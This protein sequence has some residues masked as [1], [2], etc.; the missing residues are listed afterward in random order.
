[1]KHVIYVG[2]LNVWKIDHRNVDLNGLICLGFKI[3]MTLPNN[4][5][6]SFG[7]GLDVYLF[8]NILSNTHTCTLGTLFVNQNNWSKIIIKDYSEYL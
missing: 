1:M 8:N 2:M 5:K 7:N 6:S 4:S 3:K